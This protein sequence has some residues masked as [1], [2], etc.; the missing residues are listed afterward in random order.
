MSGVQLYLDYPD[1]TKEALNLSTSLSHEGDPLPDIPAGGSTQYDAK[2]VL[3]GAEHATEEIDATVQYS[4][5]NNNAV[6]K[7]EKPYDVEISSAPLSMSVNGPSQ[8]AAAAPVEFS[9][10]LTPNSVN[11]LGNI[12]LTASYPFGFQFASSTPAPTYGQS[13]WLFPALA[14]SSSVQVTIVGRLQGQENDQQTLRFLA[15]TQSTLDP[16]NI[17]LIYLSQ[18]Q[19]VAINRSPVDVELALN[20]QNSQ[21]GSGNFVI[22]PGN[23]SGNITLTNNLPTELLNAQV[24]VV[25]AGPALDPA[26]VSPGENG[27]YRQDSQTITWDKISAPA[28]AQISPGQALN[29]DFSF[30][31]LSVSQ[32]Q[33]LQN[34]DITFAVSVTGTEQGAASNAA[35]LAATTQGTARLA[36]SV[37]LVAHAVYSTGPFRNS[38]PVPPVVDTPTTY[39]VLWTLTNTSNIVSGGTVTATLPAYVHWIGTV[40]PTTANVTFNANNNTV[41]WTP[42]DLPAS[43]SSPVA[44][45]AFQ[46]QILPM[47]S[48][49]GS[50][51]DLVDNIS[52]SGTD[53][54]VNAPV[55]ASTGYLSTAIT[56]DPNYGTQ[57]GFVVQ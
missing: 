42:G 6:F 37:G 4:V 21:N 13:E 31:S 45:V 16:K 43:G 26:S 44:S 41:T 34:G 39:T 23:S 10:T 14:G 22:S 19:T 27:L 25:L 29:L 46:V 1:G 48:Q 35:A 9:V 51:P 40:S 17:D 54:F 15:G 47:A 57:N 24:S 12:L 7:K 8:T 5:P 53:S 52:F 11:A 3:F 50:A 20:N 36:S 32:L 30:N 33:A 49:V 18:N 55:T 28:L 38:G 56:T 2:A